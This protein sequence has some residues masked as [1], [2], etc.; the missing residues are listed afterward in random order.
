M[1]GRTVGRGA[2]PLWTTAV[3]E[4]VVQRANGRCE[5]RKGQ[6]GNR[7]TRE[8]KITKPCRRSVADG[9]ALYV[10]GPPGMSETQLARLDAS[11][12][13]AY[14]NDCAAGIARLAG[15]GARAKHSTIHEDQGDLLEGL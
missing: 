7:H 6:C 13:H 11:H 5:C 15:H 2:R 12:L 1:T 9:W 4:E 8:P 14:C 10:V 3:W